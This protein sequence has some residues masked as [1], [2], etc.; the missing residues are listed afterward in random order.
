[1]KHAL[2]DANLIIALFLRPDHALLRAAR[3]GGC[4]LAICPYVIREARRMVAGAFPARAAEF[5]QF[6]EQL[7][8]TTIVDANREEIA[9]WEGYLSDSADVPVLAAA[10]A[11]GID[12]VVT[13]DRAF[14]ADA[15]ATLAAEG[16][17]V[18]VLSVP[19]FLASL[20][21]R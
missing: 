7:P 15:R 1:V 12:A 9:R 20:D 10:I 4:R 14:R 8:A 21:V 2:I 5:E 13:S 16:D 3:S 19:E 6:I 11:A 17:P 18:A